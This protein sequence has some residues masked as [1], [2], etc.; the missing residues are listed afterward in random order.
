VATVE[1]GG[2]TQA[3]TWGRARLEPP[4]AVELDTVFHLFSGTKLYTATALMRLVEQGR[5]ALDDSVQAHLPELPLRVPITLRQLASHSSGLPETLAGLLATHFVG[6]PTPSTAEALARFRL[7]TGKAPGRVAYRN[8]NYA[9]LGELI[10]RLGGAPYERFVHDEVLAPLGAAPRYAYAPAELE[11]AATGYLPRLSP[12]RLALRLLAPDTA[13][14]L[15]AGAHGRLMALEPYALDAA[16]IGGL[17]GTI[18]DFTPLLAD[19]LDPGDG[20]LRAATKAEMLTLQ[21]E[22]AAGIVSRV[23]VGLGWKLGRVGGVEF[24]NHEGG[25][26]GFCSE[27]RL[28]PEAGLGVVVLMNLSQTAKLSRVAHELCEALR[29]R[30]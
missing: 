18:L 19:M 20:L 24:W 17:V 10:S 28:Y 12:M 14:R 22:G 1:R 9:I 26:A 27:T 25:G 13:R 16:A 11:R 7:D 15:Y 2:A 21:A 6:E 4:R 29:T 23:G 3:W 8:V 5:V 30:S